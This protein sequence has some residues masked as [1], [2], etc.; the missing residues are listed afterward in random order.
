MANKSHTDVNLFPIEIPA[1]VKSLAKLLPSMDDSLLH[2][3]CVLCKQYLKDKCFDSKGYL[4]VKQTCLSN[5]LL[6]TKSFD[7]LV[8][9][10]LMLA[11][12]CHNNYHFF[13]SHLIENYLIKSLNLNQKFVK[14]FLNDLFDDNIVGVDGKSFS[15][16][17][18]QSYVL[19]SIRWRIDVSISNPMVS[20]IMEPLIVF[21]LNVMLNNS[22][23]KDLFV[24]KVVVFECKI[25]EFHKLR[26]NI[27]NVVN[28]LNQIHL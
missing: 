25:S 21:E 3:I 15:V 22:S 8:N 11:I 4:S 23:D 12:N 26:F 7:V 13:D 10:I 18:R 2:Q 24:E 20:R 6:D 14:L 5:D 28:R 27:A 1:S 19:R 9:A 17:R 16:T